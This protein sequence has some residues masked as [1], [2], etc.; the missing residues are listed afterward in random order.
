MIK[1]RLSPSTA[2]SFFRFLCLVT[3][4]KSTLSIAFMCHDFNFKL[5]TT[6]TKYQFSKNILFMPFKWWHLKWWNIC[7]AYL[8]RRCCWRWHCWAKYCF[9][10]GKVK[11]RKT[12]CAKCFGMANSHKHTNCTHPNSFNRWFDR[13]VYFNRFIIIFVQWHRDEF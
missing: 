13:Y 7:S 3:S 11:K 8:K 9:A 1:I 6:T 12:L 10:L 5:N 2:Q 4:H